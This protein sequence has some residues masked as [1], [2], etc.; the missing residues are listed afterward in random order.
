MD[1]KTVITSIIIP[2]FSVFMGAGIVLFIRELDKKEAG[3][4]IEQDYKRSVDLRFNKIETN[5]NKNIQ[6]LK[7]I[8][9]TYTI[10]QAEII[11]N[12]EIKINTLEIEIKHSQDQYEYLDSRYKKADIKILKEFKNERRKQN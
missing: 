7:D 4:K 11:K 9:T 5:N 12:L 6:L 2:L 1:K 10:K 8:H 3:I